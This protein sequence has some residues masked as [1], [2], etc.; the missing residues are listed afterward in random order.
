MAV[1]TFA[2]HGATPLETIEAL[3]S[4]RRMERVRARSRTRASTVALQDFPEVG[5]D[6]AAA[7]EHS[8]SRLLSGRFPQ[9]DIAPFPTTSALERSDG[10]RPSQEA[11]FLP[12]GN[13]E[14]SPT[15][16]QNESAVTKLTHLRRCSASI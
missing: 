11:T 15:P 5:Q 10:A 2:L 4:Q 8:T 14:K 16:A 1:A 13:L 3:C 9:R 12:E 7:H 6:L